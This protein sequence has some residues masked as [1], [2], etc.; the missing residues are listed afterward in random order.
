M[1]VTLEHYTKINESWNSFYRNIWNKYQILNMQQIYNIPNPSGMVKVAHNL[2]FPILKRK[3]LTQ[4]KLKWFIQ[5]PCNIH[6]LHL[7]KLG[8]TNKL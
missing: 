1:Y 3:Y 6:E 5:V 4:I 7:V 2:E 8:I